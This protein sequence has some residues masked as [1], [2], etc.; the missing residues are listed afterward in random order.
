MLKRIIND[1]RIFTLIQG[2]LGKDF[3]KIKRIFGT[4]RD[5]I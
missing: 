1:F 4:L 2:Y 5:I 3:T